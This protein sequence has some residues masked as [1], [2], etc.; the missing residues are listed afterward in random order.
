MITIYS[1]YKFINGLFVNKLK[2]VLKPVF[3]RLGPT[4]LQ[5][6]RKFNKIYQLHPSG[7]TI[8][9]TYVSWVQCF[10]LLLR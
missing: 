4:R 3:Q 5:M 7:P 9:S 1:L 6:L 8:C 10:L 2:I